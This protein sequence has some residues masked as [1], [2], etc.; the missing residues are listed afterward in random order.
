MKENS[1]NNNFNSNISNNN[2]IEDNKYI[3]DNIRSSKTNNI[4]ILSNNSINSIKKTQ[5][6]KK[7]K[8]GILANPNITNKKK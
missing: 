6:C 7:K 5:K 4:L 1:P 2:N 3:K 8:K